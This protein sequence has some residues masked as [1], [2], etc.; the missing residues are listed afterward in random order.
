MMSK[1]AAVACGMALAAG[2]YAL[3]MDPKE[4]K[5]MMEKA[6]KLYENMVDAM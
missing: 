2:F 3:M 1:V 6:E 5:A 4:K